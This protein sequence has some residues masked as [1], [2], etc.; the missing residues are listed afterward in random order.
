V[1]WW[2]WCLI[3]IIAAGFVATVWLKRAGEEEWRRYQRQ[4]QVKEL[5]RQIE[6]AFAALVE[7]GG[8]FSGAVGT[9]FLQLNERM[10]KSMGVVVPPHLEG[11]RIAGAWV[12]EHHDM[13]EVEVEIPLTMPKHSYGG[14][15]CR[16]GEL[17]GYVFLL[18]SGQLHCNRCGWTCDN[19]LSEDSP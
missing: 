6:A 7:M 10:S 2:A 15:E 17:P 18:D 13:P 8:R 1:T 9:L 19:P 3:G 4:Q 12:D 14:Y 11:N 5:N 16:G